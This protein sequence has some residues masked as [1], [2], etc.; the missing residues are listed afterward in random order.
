V[1]FQAA[2]EAGVVSLTG[3]GGGEPGQGPPIDIEAVAALGAA[4]RGEEEQP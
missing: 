3:S 1:R 2:R 4:G